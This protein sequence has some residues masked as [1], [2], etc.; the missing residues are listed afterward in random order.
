MIK[1]LAA[2]FVSDA[3]APMRRTVEATTN[4]IVR[5]ALFGFLGGV[6]LLIALGIGVYALDVYLTPHFGQLATTLGIA[7]GFLALSLI[8]FIAM[9]VS[10][11]KPR[12][13][14][15]ASTMATPAALPAGASVNAVLLQVTDAMKD[16]GFAKERAALLAGAELAKNM[17]PMQLLSIALAGGF[18]VGRR[19]I[20]RR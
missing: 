10:G 18:I 13:S 14:R 16:A 4:R 8:F 11:R 17:G 6:L 5:V 9:A 20:R 15:A 12:A 19:L 2:R 1:D 7:A 3:T